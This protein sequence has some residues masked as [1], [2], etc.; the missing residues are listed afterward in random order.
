MTIDKMTYEWAETGTKTPAPSDEKIQEGFVGGDK[1][2]I[3]YF[4]WISNRQDDK[5]NRI[6]RERI[7]SFYT[8]ATDPQK[9]IMTGIW[10]DDWTENDYVYGGDTSKKYVGIA[11]YFTADNEPRLLV[12]DQSVH[13]I[14]VFD[15]RAMTLLDTSGD[16]TDDLKSSKTYYDNSI[17][18]DGTYVYCTFANSTDNTIDV[19][20]WEIDTWDVRSGWAATGTNMTG[21]STIYGG[22][23]T[24]SKIIIADDS[25]IAV[26]RKGKTV[27]DSSTE[28]ISTFLRTTGAIGTEGAGDSPASADAGVDIC[29]DGTNLY[30]T[31]HDSTPDSY[32]CSA[33]IAD[34]TASCGGANYPLTVAGCYGSAICSAGNKIVSAYVMS[35]AQVKTDIV[36]RTH[37]S[38]DADL[39]TILSGDSSNATPLTQDEYC[40]TIESMCYDGINI[41]MS[42]RTS[43]I[44][45]L[46]KI[47]AKK[48][49]I[50]DVGAGEEKSFFDVMSGCF[51]VA[52]GQTFS[53][54]ASD[55]GNQCV[56]DGR[57]V[58]ML[59]ENSD[60]DPLSGRAYRVP[61]ALLRN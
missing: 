13:K 50:R 41:W 26:V 29:S 20:C 33:T 3:E 14:D 46:V 23:E 24:Y 40:G 16:L 31:T 61:L 47:D 12:L 39:D 6:I 17:C 1:A 58:W 59:P 8:D 45:S 9:M 44:E 60:N 43:L 54:G 7:D 11:V 18:T 36:L 27:V 57:D 49:M 35:G 4:N 19:Q 56:F 53:A 2:P 30:F 55:Y 25:Y 48:I 10:D 28:L 22:S 37:N 5:I 21:T 32:V 15:P 51:H 34:V 52:D 42:C 38:T